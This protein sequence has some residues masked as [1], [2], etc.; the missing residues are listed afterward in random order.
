MNTLLPSPTSTE[1]PLREFAAR[2]NLPASADRLWHIQSG[3]VRAMTW[4]EDGT[5]IVL[6]IWG[7]GDMVGKPLGKI[8]PYHLECLTPVKASLVAI[9]QVPNLSNILLAHLQLVEELMLIRSHK[10]IDVMLLKLLSWLAKRFGQEVERGRL[11]DLRLTHQ[12]L[13]ELLG[14]TRVTVTRTLIQMEQQG[15]IQRLSLQRIVL[16]Q[17]ESWHYEI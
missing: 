16:Q 1:T 8:E 10:R 5:T 11:I 4:L 6:G 2:A 7:A 13:S 15:L 3:F 12:D 17:E 9:D 14:A